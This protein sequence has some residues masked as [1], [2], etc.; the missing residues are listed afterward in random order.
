MSRHDRQGLRGGRAKPKYQGA[1]ARAQAKHDDFLSKLEREQ[2]RKQ[3]EQ[4]DLFLKIEDIAAKIAEPRDEDA[5]VPDL[6]YIDRMFRDAGITDEYDGL[7]IGGSSDK[8]AGFI[9]LLKVLVLLYL[10]LNR[11]TS[12]ELRKE[13]PHGYKFFYDADDKPDA[14]GI[15]V[16]KTT[17]EATASAKP[18]DRVF[19]SPTYQGNLGSMSKQDANLAKGFLKRLDAA[20]QASVMAAVE[21]VT[22]VVGVAKDSV[23]R[24]SESVGRTLRDAVAT[25]AVA[26]GTYVVSGGDKTKTILAAA[27]VAGV[28]TAEAVATLDLNP[29]S[30]YG[31]VGDDINFVIASDIVQKINKFNSNTLESLTEEEFREVQ[32][33]A[34]V[35]RMTMISG[36]YNAVLEMIQLMRPVMR[37]ELV[38]NHNCGR[39]IDDFA[40]SRTILGLAL[41]IAAPTEFILKLITAENVFMTDD[42]G[43]TPLMLAARGCNKAVVEKI[44][45][46]VSKAKGEDLLLHYIERV[47]KDGKSYR[48]YATMSSDELTERFYEFGVDARRA[49]NARYNTLDTDLRRLV[50]VSKRNADKTVSC[51]HY[52]KFSDVIENAKAWLEEKKKTL[53]NYLG[54]TLHT[55]DCVFDGFPPHVGAMVTQK[56]IRSLVE[57]LKKDGSPESIGKARSIENEYGGVSPI[58]LAEDFCAKQKG[59]LRIIEAAKTCRH[60]VIGEDGKATCVDD[61]IPPTTV[62]ASVAIPADFRDNRRGAAQ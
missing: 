55:V 36:Q 4:E 1:Q 17:S 27:S 39:V 48:D 19:A 54:N 7:G 28:Q 23:V 29:P 14:D 5:A 53:E 10:Q 43:V 13:D 44:L 56:N 33:I 59:N 3:K 49:K 32:I 2:K 61:L 50:L 40:G 35:I 31:L 38:L 42:N 6:E 47:D 9:E 8:R 25:A 51:D 37:P 21:A 62:S 60:I 52:L 26:A 45:D 22:G 57:V 24:A 11:S 20:Y 34:H 46:T 30:S 16:P 15:H 18:L 12:L 58:S 41:E